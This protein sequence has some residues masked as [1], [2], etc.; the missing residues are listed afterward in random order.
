METSLRAAGE[1]GGTRRAAPVSPGRRC[2]CRRAVA[3]PEAAPAAVLEGRG[4]PGAACWGLCWARL[5]PV[6]LLPPPSFLLL[7]SCCFP[8][9]S[10]LLSSSFP[11]LLSTCFPAD[12]PAFLLPAAPRR[13]IF[14]FQVPKLAEWA[15]CANDYQLLEEVLTKP[16][17]GCT[18]PGAVSKEARGAGGGAILQP[19]ALFAAAAAGR[20]RATGGWRG[21]T[22]WRP[23]GRLAGG[24]SHS[25]GPTACRAPRSALPAVHRAVQ[26]GVWPPRRRHRRDQLLP[27]S[28]RPGLALPGPRPA[29]VRDAAL[30]VCRRRRLPRTQAACPPLV[31]W[32]HAVPAAPCCARCARAGR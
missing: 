2:R 14:A 22:A 5:R 32:T 3:A 10:L 30:L 29:A 16:P 9:A 20:G 21:T 7:P 13:Y 17:G 18:T 1:R 25:V 12:V 15:L 31:G 27:P 28:H 4:A 26:A 19:R 8:P 11:L 23:A 6:S 24:P